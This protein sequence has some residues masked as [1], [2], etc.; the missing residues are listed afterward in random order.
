MLPTE[1]KTVLGQSA[2]VAVRRA[3]AGAPTAL[4][5]HGYPDNLHVFARVVRALPAEWGYVA[6]DFPGQGRS[7]R[8][9]AATTPVERGRWLA[10]LLDACIVTEVRICAHDMGVHAALELA[11]QA[12]KRVARMVLVHALLDSHA[13]VAKEIRWLRAA[14]AYRLLLANLPGTVL[15]RCVADFLPGNDTLPWPVEV[16]LGQCFDRA[17]GKHTAAVCD[18]TEEWL[19]RGLDAYRDLQ[20]PIVQL[21]GTRN[22][23]FGREH[24]EALQRVL[25]QALI[26]SVFDAWHWLV[27]QKPEAVVAA[28]VG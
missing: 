2:R 11:R 5:L 22:L 25:P 12:P 1:T 20:M 6:A 14:K 13:K 28:L 8:A 15:R 19:T 7:A 26:V 18:A 4:F 23:Y 3:R 17:V 27:W 16:E 24:A 9:A 21:V 10:A